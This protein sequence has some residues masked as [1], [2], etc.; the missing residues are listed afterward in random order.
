VCGDYGRDADENNASLG[1]SLSGLFLNFFL[2]L[3]FVYHCNL[4]QNGKTSYFY[5]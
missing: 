1:V 2:I 4:G 3:V 5:S